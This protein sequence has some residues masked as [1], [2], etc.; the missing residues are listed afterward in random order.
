MVDERRWS[1]VDE[2]DFT[3]MGLLQLGFK[4]LAKSPRAG[5]EMHWDDFRKLTHNADLISLVGDA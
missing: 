4:I 2:R 1:K 5:A 3:S